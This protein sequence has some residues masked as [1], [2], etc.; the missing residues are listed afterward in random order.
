MFI[1]KYQHVAALHE[2]K[3]NNAYELMEAYIWKHLRQW[4]LD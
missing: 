1:L 4:K 3:N 2:N